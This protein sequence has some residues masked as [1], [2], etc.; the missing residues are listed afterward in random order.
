MGS[1]AA[2]FMRNLSYGRNGTDHS[3]NTPLLDALLKNAPQKARQYGPS[4]EQEEPWDTPRPQEEPWDT[5][6]PTRR[7]VRR[8]RL[9]EGFIPAIFGFLVGCVVW[10]IGARYTIDGSIW[11]IN[12]LMAFIGVPYAIEL[13]WQLY[14]VL[15]WLPVLISIIEWRHSPVQM[16]NGRLYFAPLSI[17][18]IWLCALLLDLST[19]H[20]GLGIVREG[21][22]QIEVWLATT[23]W[24][25]TIITVFL[26]LWPE[27]VMRSSLQHITLL[28]RGG[29]KRYD[30]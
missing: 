13:V 29:K 6:P 18:S 11:I 16:I 25:K 10:A 19:T 5:P 20:S 8:V 9:E 15:I 21:A 1:C 26:T 2:T 28:F 3:E 12:W 14:L 24:A 30:V 27:W 23:V 17:I 4:P 22:G 7:R